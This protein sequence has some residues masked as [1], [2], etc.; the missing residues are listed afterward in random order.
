VEIR[1]VSCPVTTEDEDD[2]G[3]ADFWEM[4]YYGSLAQIAIGDFDSDG[5]PNILEAAI[6]SSL[7]SRNPYALALSVVSTSV[8]PNP[9]FEMD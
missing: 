9:S 8:A 1:L 5:I 7:R 3:M 6:G 2:D 4:T